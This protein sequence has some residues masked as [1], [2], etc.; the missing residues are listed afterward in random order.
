MMQKDLKKIRR[1]GGVL[2]MGGAMIH[3]GTKYPLQTSRS[4]N[5]N[6]DKRQ[7]KVT[8]IISH[9]PHK[10]VIIMSLNFTGVHN[11]SFK[12][13]EACAFRYDCLGAKDS[14]VYCAGERRLIDGQTCQN[15]VI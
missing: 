13:P 15:R 8:L 10:R 5:K 4:K 3:P 6:V 11:A 9:L 12:W 14:I 7:E 2:K 1:Q